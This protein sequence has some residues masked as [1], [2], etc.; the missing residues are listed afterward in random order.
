MASV[1]AS[2]VV[3]S[4]CGQ[5]FKCSLSSS[6]T[7]FFFSPGAQSLPIST[8][9]KKK[10]GCSDQMLSWLTSRLVECLAALKTSALW[11]S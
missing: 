8:G 9:I 4:L 5:M 11:F 3:E 7:V 10:K 2:S 6:C 1:S